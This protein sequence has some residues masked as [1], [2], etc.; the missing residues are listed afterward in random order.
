MCTTQKKKFIG[1]NFIGFLTKFNVRQRNWKI[2]QKKN[3]KI[4]F[5]ILLSGKNR[6]AEK[7]AGIYLGIASSSSS[8][9]RKQKAKKIK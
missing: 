3:W 4:K 9:F 5:E 6:Q 2:N 1:E 8:F 7:W